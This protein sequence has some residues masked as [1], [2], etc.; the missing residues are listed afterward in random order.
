ME[1]VTNITP[2]GLA[3][4]LVMGVL[5]IALPFRY[6]AIPFLIGSIYITLGQKIVIGDLDFTML[7]ILIL[8]GWVRILIRRE[9]FLIK[10]NSIDIIIF[11]W[12]LSSFTAYNLLWQTKEAFINQLGFL[13]SAIGIYIFFRIILLDIINI[14]ISIKILLI[15]IVPLAFLMIIEMYTGKNL[16]SVFGGVPEYSLIRYGEIR[17]QG[18]FRHPILVGTFAASL[19]PFFLMQ[20]WDGRTGKLTAIFGIIATSAIVITAH[21]SGPVLTY[22][23]G[24]IGVLLWYFR[25]YMRFVRWSILLV[26]IL[27]SLVMKAPVYYIIAKIS[28]IVGGTGW[29]RS[30]LIDQAINYFNEWWLLGTTYTAHWMP[31]VLI[32]NPDSADITNHY[33]RQG[34]NGGLLTL[35]LFIFIIILSF[36]KIGLKI[37][38]LSSQNDYLDFFPEGDNS[39]LHQYSYVDTQEKERMIWSFGVVLS[40]HVVSFISV[41]YFDQ[42]IVFWYFLLAAISCHTTI[43]N[44][45]E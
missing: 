8:F 13:Y 15:I 3:F 38:A 14:E 11:A 35:I 4:T 27:F 9:I 39:S 24:I 41:S 18:S 34:V 17:C 36:R 29:H 12:M 26:L 7:R 33:I 28:G 21:S 32:S 22:G 5:V 25:E 44:V 40:V 30:Y 2:L 19:M 1:T 42:I 45:E 10:I 43:S 16:F 23:I 20:W 31:T 6:A 37:K